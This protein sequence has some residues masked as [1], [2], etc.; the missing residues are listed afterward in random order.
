MKIVVW[1]LNIIQFLIVYFLVFWLLHSGIIGGPGP[2]GLSLEGLWP[3]ISIG[4]AVIPWRYYKRFSL[5]ITSKK[6]KAPTEEVVAEEAS[7]TNEKKEEIIIKELKKAKPMSILKKILVTIISL[8][9]ISIVVIVGVISYENYTRYQRYNPKSE[10]FDFQYRPNNNNLTV[11]V[12]GLRHLKKDMSL[13]SGELTGFNESSTSFKSHEDEYGRDKYV[14]ENIY[15]YAN[16]LNGK[17]NGKMHEWRSITKTR[18]KWG[19]Q[20]PSYYI[21]GW[22]TKAFFKNGKEVGY[23]SKWHSNGQLL[24]KIYYKNNLKNGL[25]ETW[26]SDGQLITRLHYE[27]DL[28]QGEW[29]KWDFDGNLIKHWVM[30]D[31]IPI[32]KIVN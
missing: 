27:N 18:S 25:Y 10:N 29:K 9:L 15:F 14:Y 32:E 4:I 19:T 5:F 2:R 26:N 31:G 17:L 22:Q 20:Y 3:A 8:V 12:N 28:K 6:M 24:Y 13:F 23:S 1:V 16:Y 21:S 7:N 30:K 11:E